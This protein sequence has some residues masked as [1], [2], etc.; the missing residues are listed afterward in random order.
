MIYFY[1]YL[2]IPTRI[3]LEKE[4]RSYANSEGFRFNEKKD[5]YSK[6]KNVSF[7]LSTVN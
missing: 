3:F 6:H 2:L 1:Y 4:C 5:T 7:V